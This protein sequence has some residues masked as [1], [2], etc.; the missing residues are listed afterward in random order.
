MPSRPRIKR[1]VR[2]AI[3]LNGGID[4]VAATVDRGRSVVGDWNNL[5]HTALPNLEYALAMDE[6]AVASGHEPPITAAL[7]RALGGVFVPLPSVDGTGGE[8]AT[9]LVGIM[10]RMGPL[11]AE[12]RLAMADGTCDSRE[13]ARMRDELAKLIA[14]AS[15]FDAQLM[16]YENG[17]SEA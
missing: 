16:I 12:V 1:A 8:I 13:A 2:A 4:G 11:A 14:S 7:S 10:E 3:A 15:A 5:S 6:I 9:G 17:E